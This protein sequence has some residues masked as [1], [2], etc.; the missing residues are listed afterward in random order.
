MEPT[1]SAAP[2]RKITVA[3]YL[4]IERATEQKHEFVDGEVFAMAGASRQHNEIREN[5]GGELFARLKGGSC[6]TYSG[7]QRVKV[8]R[9]G[10]SIYTYPD[11]LIVCGT[12]QFVHE[13]GLDTLLNPQVIFEILSDS[14][15]DYDRGE[16]FE[17]YRLLPSLREYVLISQREMEVEQ[18][19]RQSDGRWEPAILRGADAELVLATAPVR[20]PLADLYRGVE[21]AGPVT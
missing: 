8:E 14:T 19:S 15:E 13:Q 18:R 20:L 10:Q 4:A 7:D 17:Y 12:P 11:Y 21:L 9:D 6:R 1:M 16:K 3:E 2:H 5:L